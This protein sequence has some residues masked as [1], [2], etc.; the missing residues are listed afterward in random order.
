MNDGTQT[1]NG[2]SLRS[3]VG[4]IDFDRVGIMGHSRGGQGINDAIQLNDLR[5]GVTL[6]QL[7]AATKEL[8]NERD[9][10]ASNVWFSATG[11]ARTTG[12]KQAFLATL[13][14]LTS[15]LSTTGISDADLSAALDSN[16]I[17]LAASAATGPNAPPKYV[18]KAAL[19]L[20]PTD[21][22]NF[23][24]IA[25]VPFA[26]MVPSCDGD[27]R[28][29]N[30]VNVFDHNRF[31]K[32]AADTAPRFQVVVRGANHNYFNSQWT[33][34]DYSAN[35]ADYCYLSSMTKSG[36][37]LA[38]ADQAA[39]GLFVIDSFM[40][41]FV[42]GE[43][44][45]AP[46]WNGSAPLPAQAC[47]GG[48]AP[49]DSRVAL[50]VQTNGQTNGVNNHKLIA[51]FDDTYRLNQPYD[52]ASTYLHAGDPL[53]LIDTSAF[54]GSVYTCATDF[55]LPGGRIPTCT[56][57]LPADA[58]FRSAVST[59]VGGLISV[60]NQLLLGLTRP[61]MPLTFTLKEPVPGAPA[62]A[63]SE[64]A[65]STS[66]YDTL[67]FRIAM[68]RPAQ[69][70]ETLL[71]RQEATVTLTDNNGVSSPA[72]KVSDFSDALDSSMQF[73]VPAGTRA[74]ELLNMVAIPLAAFKPDPATASAFDPARL[75]TMTLRFANSPNDGTKVALTDVQ[76]Q[77][78]GRAQP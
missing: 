20:A 18:F 68:I 62:P 35:A 31:N 7:R 28:N 8:Q 32:D 3:L 21:G 51:P 30:G 59:Y 25:N 61:D 19:S 53:D 33:G 48:K 47:P 14:A 69:P 44:A 73:A 1:T 11:A 54:A 15:A 39:V 57:S 41:N 63:V 4:R 78:L 26:A 70:T 50:S 23:Q 27:V 43:T 77:I 40:R 55:A 72:I 76:L 66:G 34:D 60:P 56:P 58:F 17:A 37:R 74:A 5:L 2:I 46:Y 10:W 12:T 71:A 6:Q 22:R 64:D 24:K 38:P 9:V 65:L 45:F 52:S 67:S 36:L 42:G 29:L 49:C 75:K 16:N 13:N